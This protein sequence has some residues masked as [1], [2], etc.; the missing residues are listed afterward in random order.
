M[1][2][3]K[4]SNEE[5]VSEKNI[6]RLVIEAWERGGR[7]TFPAEIVKLI[8]EYWPNKQAK[9]FM[10]RLLYFNYQENNQ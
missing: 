10:V 4:Q 6:V 8:H 5:D 2:A 9:P 1:A 7:K 3:E